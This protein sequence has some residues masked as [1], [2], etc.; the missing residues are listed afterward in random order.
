MEMSSPETS[1]APSPE[2]PAWWVAPASHPGGGTGLSW[3]AAAGPP[4]DKNALQDWQDEPRD[5]KVKFRPLKISVNT[6][7]SDD[8]FLKTL[9]EILSSQSFESIWWGNDGNCIV[10]GE[11]L[12][13]KE[14]LGR[15]GPRKIFETESMRGFLLQLM[16]HGFRRMEGDSPLLTSMEELRAVAAAGAELGKLLFYSNPHFT[17]DDPSCHQRGV[18]SAGESLTP[19]TM[20]PPGA[21]KKAELPWKRWW[22]VQLA[23]G[24]EEEEEDEGTQTSTSTSPE[25]GADTPPSTARPSP[26]KRPRRRSPAGIQ[27]AAPAPSTASLPWL[28]PPAPDRSLAVPTLPSGQP[29]PGATQVPGAGLAPLCAPRFGMDSVG[30]PPGHCP[31]CSCGGNSGARPQQG[32][33]WEEQRP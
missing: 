20:S 23:A 24:V 31:T 13:R 3:D 16:F 19:P 18:E 27:E 6:K 11:K 5:P 25:P 12:F 30:S 28:T 32:Q 2:E 22:D 10:I 7:P 1:C 15:R 26:P 8:S 4:A 29:N 33:D 9:W 14:V 21:R 17:R